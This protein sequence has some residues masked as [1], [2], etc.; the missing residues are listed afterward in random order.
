MSSRE[1]EGRVAVVT[2]AGHGFGRVYAEFLASKGASVLVNDEGKH[3]QVS[4]YPFLS[5]RIRSRGGIAVVNTDSVLT[6]NK[7]IEAAVAEFGSIHILIN[8]ATVVPQPKNFEELTDAE[9]SDATDIPIKGSFMTTSAAWKYFRNQAYGRVVNV[10]SIAALHG[11]PQQATYCTAKHSQIGYSFTLAKE[12]A[13]RGI[14]VNVVIPWGVEP[15]S[16]SIPRDVVANL[17]L[18][19]SA[20]FVAFLVHEKNTTESGNAYELGAGQVIKLRWQRSG[21]LLLR[22]DESLGPGAVIKNWSKV[23]NY[24]KSEHPSGPNRFLD[25]LQDGLKLPVND[26][27]PSVSFK[28]RAVLVTGAGSGLGRAYALH[29]ARLGASV[30]VNDVADPSLV[31]NEIRTLGGK[32][33]GVVGSAEQGEKNV[34]A[35]VRA[36]GRIDIVVNNAGILRDKAFHNMSVPMWDQVLSVHL[37]GTYATSRA[38]WP[39]FVRQKYGRIV[40]TTSVTGIYGAFGQANYAAAKSAIIGLTRALAREGA[41]HNILVN[42]IAPNAGTNMTKSIL[43]DEVAKALKP[44]HIAPLV[45][46]L[47]SDLVPYN[48]T[49]GLYEV[50]SG[51]FGKTRWERQFGWSSEGLSSLANLSTF[52]SSQPTYPTSAGEH[53]DL[54]LNGSKLVRTNSA[55]E[56]L[57]NIKQ[58]K[59]SVSQGTKYTYSERDLILFALSIGA[60]QTDLPLVFEGHKDFK[61]LPVFGLIPFFNARPL[62]KMEDI[63]HNYD[64]RKLLHVDQYLEI[65]SPVPFSGVLSTFPKLIQVIDKGKDAMVVQGFTTV[66]QGNKTVFYNETTV[67]VRGAGGFGG[68]ATVADRGAATAKNS[69]PSRAADHIVEEKTS[70]GQAALYRLNGDYNPLHVDPEFSQRGGFKVPI[71]HGL[72]SLSIAGKHVFQ[73]YGPYKNLKGRF[74]SVVIPGQTLRTEMWKEND[75]VI[76]Q[77]TVKETSKKAITSAAVELA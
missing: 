19:S 48:T 34:D 53:L 75:K 29:F 31:V 23:D 24:E 72:C 2:G 71:L 52:G 21:G 66:D 50:G 20:A 39:H 22:A 12:G 14:F 76:F 49:G 77:V 59:A 6:G 55:G 70:A 17:S 69:P 37:G 40:N 18:D 3:K 10:S 45:S 33:E 65:R 51:W 4:R 13:K 62:Y 64:Q 43:S 41:K 56:V 67:L 7:I 47:C 16:E 30:M 28:G 38:A 68:D 26:A 15:K 1:F 9:W 74:S 54:L 46:A 27:L 5:L 36:F 25:L 35:T 63:M 42:V 58:A 11:L 60:S 44:D 8:A 57:A 61:A 73:M 32:A